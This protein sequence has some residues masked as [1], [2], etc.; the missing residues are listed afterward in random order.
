MRL[1]QNIGTAIVVILSVLGFTALCVWLDVA[2]TQL[3]GAGIVVLGAITLVAH[4]L[5][6]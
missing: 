6:R 1:V 3:V 4:L 2:P 5:R